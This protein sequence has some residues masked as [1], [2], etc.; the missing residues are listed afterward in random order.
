MRLRFT[1]FLYRSY[2][3]IVENSDGLDDAIKHAWSSYSPGT[4]G[5]TAVALD[6]DDWI[7]T[8]TNAA[9]GAMMKV[10]YNLMSGKLL[11]NGLPLDQPP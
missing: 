2:K 1:R 5:W 9:K 8:D 3:R 11:V 7:T 10:H 4:S 6:V